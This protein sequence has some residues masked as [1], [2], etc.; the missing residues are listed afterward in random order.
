MDVGIKLVVVLLLLAVCRFDGVLLRMYTCPCRPVVYCTYLMNGKTVQMRRLGS[1]NRVVKTISYLVFAYVSRS[2]LT[3]PHPTSTRPTIL[4][5]YG[6]L[7]WIHHHTNSVPLLPKELDYENEAANQRK[8]KAEFKKRKCKV[9]VP[10]VHSHLTS[11]R[12]L[13]TEWVDGVK[14]ADAPSE[15]IRDLIPVGVELFLTQLL[16]IGAF[17]ADP[18]SHLGLVSTYL[19]Y[20]MLCYLMLFYVISFHVRSWR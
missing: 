1:G 5:E 7:S 13:T 2:S 14:L 16:D 12:V 20:Y 19:C 9:H 11:R 10:G 18:V 17:H 4:F 6:I 3:F 15:Q 8:F